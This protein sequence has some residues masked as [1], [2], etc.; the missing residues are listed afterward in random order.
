V[1]SPETGSLIAPDQP[2]AGDT[3]A[4]VVVGDVGVALSL[5]PTTL[6]ITATIEAN[7]RFI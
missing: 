2:P 6:T 3:T 1:P 5:Q 7:R 4:G